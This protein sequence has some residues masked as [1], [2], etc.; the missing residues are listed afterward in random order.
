MGSPLSKP[1][2]SLLKMWV[3]GIHPMYHLFRKGVAYEVMAGLNGIHRQ[4]QRAK[5]QEFWHFEVDER[6]IRER[7]SML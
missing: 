4:T 3:D 6:G 1:V 7:R 5:I 2:E